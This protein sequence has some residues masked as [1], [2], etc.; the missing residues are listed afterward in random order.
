MSKFDA[1]GDIFLTIFFRSELSACKLF[2]SFYD[3]SKLPQLSDFLL[4]ENL[5]S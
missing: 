4:M 1:F 5:F 3:R 2:E